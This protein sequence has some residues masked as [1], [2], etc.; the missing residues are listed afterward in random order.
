MLCFTWNM[1][2]AKPLEEELEHWLPK[3]GADFD[4]IAIG[5]QECSYSDWTKS[6]Q[7]TKK[8]RKSLKGSQ[9]VQIPMIS[10]AAEE[11]M[12]TLGS[13]ISQLDISPVPITRGVSEQ[14]CSFHWDDILA[15]RLG[16]G[17][18][19]V[20]QAVLM[21]MRLLVFARA[22]HC[23]CSSWQG[24]PLVHTVKQTYSAT[25]LLAG[26]VGNKGGLVVS[27]HFGPVSLCF[28]SCHLAAHMHAADKRDNDCK[29][30]LQ[31]TWPVCHP[32]LDLTNQFDHCFWFGDLNYRVELKPRSEDQEYPTLALGHSRDS[33]KT[34]ATIRTK[35]DVEL[36]FS[37]ADSDCFATLDSLVR[38]GKFRELMSYDQLRCHRT[39]GKAFVGF[40]EGQPSFA[41]TFKVER[42]LGLHHVQERAPSY[43]DRILWK[44]LPPHKGNVAQHLFTSAPGVTSSDHKP[45]LAHFHIS[46]S[47]EQGA[48]LQKPLLQECFP[49]VRLTSFKAEGLAGTASTSQPHL[50]F[51]VTPLELNATESM[52]TAQKKTLNPVWADHELPILRPAASTPQ[53]LASCTLLAIVYNKSTKLGC[54]A[55]RFPGFDP[56]HGP[57]ESCCYAFEEPIVLW[58]QTVDTGVL[59]GKIH[60]DW[61][62]EGICSANAVEADHPKPANHKVR[63]SCTMQ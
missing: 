19:R 49:V 17:F 51:L 28:V 8:R 23:D 15:E 30:I 53:E 42:K 56:S 29:E 14:I 41:P 50:V 24:G 25:G 43:C 37:D 63:C 11:L 1:G 48:L 22:E 21:N 39:A 40:Q 4:L 54:V 20:Q 33:G 26:T 7:R 61:T 32:R 3:E 27:L 10:G 6:P 5:V 46:A 45:V 18:V 47:A 31:E 38:D 35:A 16:D 44:S 57:T 2:D 62:A 13:P 9:A 58:N 60:V 34:N 36:R 55:L 52:S 59:S 12:H